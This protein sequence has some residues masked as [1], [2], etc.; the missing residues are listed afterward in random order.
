MAT[1]IPHRTCCPAVEPVRAI[2][3]LLRDIIV[4]KMPM[5]MF[6]IITALCSIRRIGIWA[7]GSEFGRC[8]PWRSRG[9]YGA[10]ARVVLGESH[11]RRSS[12][13]RRSVDGRW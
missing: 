9:R 8:R 3:Q 7:R 13:G 6:A 11:A 10:A 5:A 4:S 1:R 12:T 2:A